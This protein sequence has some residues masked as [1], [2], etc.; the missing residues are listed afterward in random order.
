MA[1]GRSAA[2]R[3]KEGG[4]VAHPA[5]IAAVARQPTGNQRQDRPLA[6]RTLCGPRPASAAPKIYG[7]AQETKLEQ[8][9]ARS[10]TH[11]PFLSH[12]PHALFRHDARTRTGTH[13]LSPS[14]TTAASTIRTTQLTSLARTRGQQSRR[15]PVLPPR[16]CHLVLQVPW[17]KFMA[18]PTVKTAGVFCPPLGCGSKWALGSPSER[19]AGFSDSLSSLTRS[20]SLHD[21][22]WQGPRPLRSLGV[23]RPPPVSVGGGRRRCLT[24]AQ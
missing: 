1:T 7:N 15:A 5:L 12:S 21:P 6:Q 11:T 20:Q 3:I 17:P 10:H 13:T 14:M 24:Q 16:S 18:Q 22:P 4:R 8:Q 19:M 9:H 2:C 23:C